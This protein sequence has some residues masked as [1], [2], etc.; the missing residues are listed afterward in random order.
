MKQVGGF[1][2][3]AYAKKK[4]VTFRVGI[5]FISVAQAMENLNAE[6]PQSSTFDDI[7]QQAN[8]TWEKVLS[9]IEVANM[10]GYFFSL[11]LL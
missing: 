7:A 8:E 9:T 2:K 10:E 11:S 5:S 4:S 6:A 1:F 3:F